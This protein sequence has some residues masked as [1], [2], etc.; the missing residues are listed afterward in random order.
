MSIASVPEHLGVGGDVAAPRR[1]EA[2]QLLAGLGLGRCRI[3]GVERLRAGEGGERGG[4][5]GEL[6]RLEREQLIAGLAACN[7]PVADWL[8][9][10]SVCTALRAPSILLTAPA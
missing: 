6:L 8:A 3:G 4:E 1:Q 10:T 9:V 2:A 5:I 7:A